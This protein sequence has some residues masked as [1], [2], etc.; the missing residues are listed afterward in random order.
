[1]LLASTMSSCQTP[2]SCWL[3]RTLGS[4]NVLKAISWTTVVWLCAIRK[5]LSVMLQLRPLALTSP[6]LPIHPCATIGGTPQVLP[7]YHV[8]I[9]MQLS[10]TVPVSRQVKHY[11]NRAVRLMLAFTASS[12]I[13]RRAC[14]TPLP[15][16][17]IRSQ[18]NRHSRRSRHSMWVAL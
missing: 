15:S 6:P 13:V 17:N 1:M 12:S 7:L 9:L 11:N 8:F 14:K 2:M 10:L 3:S 5:P 4:T 18:H 16:M